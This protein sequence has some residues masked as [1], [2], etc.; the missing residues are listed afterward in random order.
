[1]NKSLRH[2]TGMTMIELMIV[3]MLLGVLF[4]VAVVN[5]YELI[6]RKRL[7]RATEEVYN[8]LKLAHSESIKRQTTIY[9]SMKGGENWCIGIDN[10]ASC[11][12]RVVDSCQFDGIENVVRFNQLPDNVLNITGYIDEIGYKSV[13]FEGIRGTS[14]ASGS[15]SISRAGLRTTV[16]SNLIGMVDS[17]S[18]D[19]KS[20]N[21]C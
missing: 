3:G 2:H 8:F 19:I 20:Y 12:C 14:N 1:M 15:I 16:S 5:F 18:N 9:L 13:N 11:D 21:P 17:C 10:L 7:S 4:S 6:E